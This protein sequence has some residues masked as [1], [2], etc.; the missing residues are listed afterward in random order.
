[1]SLSIQT[2]QLTI[3]KHSSNGVISH[4]VYL[5]CEKKSFKTNK[6]QVCPRTIFVEKYLGFDLKKSQSRMQ[7]I[8]ISTKYY[9]KSGTNNE[10]TD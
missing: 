10:K 7:C 3:V 1:M 2:I 9:A 5:Q 8:L 6:A 4:G